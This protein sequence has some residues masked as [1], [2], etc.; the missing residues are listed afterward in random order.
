MF[1]FR[2]K[3]DSLGVLGAK[4]KSLCNRIKCKWT[5]TT[6]LN[7]LF[8]HTVSGCVEVLVAKE[9]IPPWSVHNPK[10]MTKVP[11]ASVGWSDLPKNE[12]EYLRAQ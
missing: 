3:C 8:S 6:F 7:Y 5:T 11:Q 2:S 1:D 10:P 12:N 4:S 9:K